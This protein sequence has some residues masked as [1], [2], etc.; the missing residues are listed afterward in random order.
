MLKNRGKPSHFSDCVFLLKKHYFASFHFI[1]LNLF[2]RV[3]SGT[4]TNLSIEEYSD[5]S[6]GLDLE[7]LKRNAK[8]LKGI[9]I[10]LYFKF[11]AISIQNKILK[12]GR[13]FKLFDS[14]V[15]VLCLCLFRL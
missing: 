12:Y 10:S 8:A 3:M 13:V 7:P 15:N 2:V 11:Y 1:F 5:W 9:K 4:T 14:V 6:S